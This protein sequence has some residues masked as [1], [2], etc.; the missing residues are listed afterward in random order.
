[1]SDDTAQEPSRARLPHS[2][3]GGWYDDEPITEQQ[4]AAMTTSVEAGELPS[5][6][7]FVVRKLLAEVERLRARLGE[8]EMQPGRWRRIRRPDG[9]LWMETSDHGEAQA[10]AERTGWPLERLYV[11]TLT[12]WRPVEQGQGRDE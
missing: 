8:I 9:S 3:E 1:V 7:R 11:G 10:E 6:S 4:L 2:H 12:E 5:Y